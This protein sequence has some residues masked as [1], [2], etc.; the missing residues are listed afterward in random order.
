MLRISIICA[1]TLASAAA[2]HVPDN[3]DCKILLQVYSVGSLKFYVVFTHGINIMCYGPT[4]HTLPL[5]SISYQIQQYLLMFAW[6]SR[7]ENQLPSQHVNYSRVL[8]PA[9]KKHIVVHVRCEIYILASLRTLHSTCSDYSWD[10]L[11][12]PGE[13]SMMNDFSTRNEKRDLGLW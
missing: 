8:K 10:R 12:T 3:L 9:T 1:D 13:V 7:E 11:W 4:T 2:F 6:S 5:F